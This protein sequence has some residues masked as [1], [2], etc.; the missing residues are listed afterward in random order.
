MPLLLLY[1][2]MI[3]WTSMLDVAREEMHVPAEAKRLTPPRAQPR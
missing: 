1:F 2:P 3:L